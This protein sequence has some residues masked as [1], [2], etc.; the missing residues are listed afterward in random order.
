MSLG[1]SGTSFSGLIDQV[2]RIKSRPLLTRSM[3]PRL[4]VRSEEKALMVSLKPGS[5]KISTAQWGGYLSVS[6]SCLEK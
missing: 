6:E 4:R 5:K 1:E 3:A 2:G